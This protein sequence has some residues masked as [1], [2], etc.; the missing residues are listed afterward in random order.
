MSA[1]VVGQDVG[2]GDD[3]HHSADALFVE[4]TAFG[5]PEVLSLRHEPVR[6]PG[7]G[8]VLLEVRAAGVNPVDWKRYS[9][10]M[11]ADPALLPLRLGFEAAGVVSA[12]GPGAAGP[13][14]PIAVGDEAIA[15]RVAGAYA[16]RLVVPASAVVPKPAALGWPEA[17]GLMLA[18][19]TA[20]HALTV[21]GVG[22]G[23]TVLIHAAA[24]GV[25]S[26][27][28][29]VARDRGARVIGTASE[30]RHAYLRELGAEPVAY[31]EGLAERVRA[32]APAGVDA[33]IDAVGTDEAI[34]VSL[35]LVDD[36]TRIATIAAFQRGAEAGIRRL[37]GAPGADQGQE[38][39]AAARLELVDLAQHGRLR[40]SA[41]P[42]PLAHVADAH[43]K[44]L[45]G[46]THGKLVLVP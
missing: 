34:D 21:T 16:T 23:D 39:R 11:G 41:E 17:G 3:R 42:F 5:G 18:G 4:A 2:M 45:E 32:L 30:A 14:G 22:E 6:D 35:E 38:I 43:R 10:D 1:R 46:H 7:P 19:A 31:G 27:A 20:V 37:G 12:V 36:R 25:G 13:R 40:I 44:G 28:V 15:F 26:I 29:Q 33:A 8:E 24:G 9:G